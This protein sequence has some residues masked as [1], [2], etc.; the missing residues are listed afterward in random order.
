[1]SI[2][3]WHDPGRRSL[4]MY[5]SDTR[6]AFYV[7]FHGGYG[8]LEVRLPASRGLRA[9]ASRPTRAPTANCRSVRPSRGRA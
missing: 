1:M 6:E 7:F 5:I 2:E 8:P 9:T 3:Q 4:G